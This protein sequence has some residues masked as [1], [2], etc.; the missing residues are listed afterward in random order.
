M[1]ILAR[2]IP[3]VLYVRARLR[4]DRDK[5]HNTPL[6]V[7]MHALGLAVIAALAFFHVLPLLAVAAF[8]VLLVRAVVGLS[9]LRRKVR[10]NTI[11][12]MEVGYGLLTV[13]AVAVGVR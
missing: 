12:F 1:V 11:G 10:V 6:V 3:S 4:L 7:G 8:L 2:A 13:L 9:R 5:P